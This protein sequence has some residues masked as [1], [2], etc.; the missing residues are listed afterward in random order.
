MAEVGDKSMCGDQ[1]SIGRDSVLGTRWIALVLSVG[2][3]AAA[4]AMSV[5]GASAAT[6]GQRTVFGTEVFAVDLVGAHDS[7]NRC[8]S[9]GDG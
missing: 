2:L 6:G 5:A 9:P 4:L 8:A 1:R 7:D 3:V